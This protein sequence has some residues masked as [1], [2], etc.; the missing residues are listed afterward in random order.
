[1]STITTWI[2]EEEERKKQLAAAALE[3]EWQNAA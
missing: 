2:E 1:V 3:K